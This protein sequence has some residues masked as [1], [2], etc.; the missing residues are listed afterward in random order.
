MI[1]VFSY[2]GGVQSTAALVLA[3]QGKIN[4]PTFLFCNVGE[5]SENPA[6]LDYVRD[7]ARP[8]AAAHGIELIELQKT[9]FQEPETLYQHLTRPGSRSIGIPVRMNGSGAPG[10]RSCTA[11]F[12]ILVVD[13]WLKEHTAG[14]YIQ[15][16]KEALLF[17]YALGKLDKETV[18]KVIVTLNDF[19][20][21]NE[22]AAHVGLGISL[23]EVERVKPN[24]DPDTI[25]WKENV[26]PLLDEVERPL[27]RQ[28]CMNVIEHAGLPIPPKSS[29][30]FCPYHKLSVWQEMRQNQPALFWRA[31]ELEKFLN[32]RRSSLGLDP[33]WFTRLLKP[34]DQATHEYGQA[35]LFDDEPMDACESG[36]CMEAGR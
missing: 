21:E 1:R 30:W 19:Y 18:Q 17:R 9:R 20:Q 8:Y 16:L 28:D 3:A 32:E 7:Y 5:D 13:R 24:S 10:R 25:A 35:G 22:P 27:T 36:Y 2:G 23:D 29:C 6:T 26:F 31:V 33:V 34:L 14:G 4:F 15:A 12:K 11:D